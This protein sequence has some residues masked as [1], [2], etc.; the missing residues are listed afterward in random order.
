MMAV[1]PT[2]LTIVMPLWHEVQYRTASAAGPVT[3]N[4][5]VVVLL[6][7]VVE[8]VVDGHVHALPDKIGRPPMHVGGGVVLI[9]AGHWLGG[10]MP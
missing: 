7:D 10:Y 9:P 6:V 8:D 3:G 4:V 1:C 2:A 5:V